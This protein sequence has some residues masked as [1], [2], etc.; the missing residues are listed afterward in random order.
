MDCEVPG[1]SLNRMTGLVVHT[2][3]PLSAA[4]RKMS[5]SSSQRLS[6]QEEEDHAERGRR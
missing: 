5:K 2:L 6:P 3:C 1:R 4:E